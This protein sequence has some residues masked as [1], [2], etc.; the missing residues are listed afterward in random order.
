MIK[1]NSFMPLVRRIHNSQL[2]NLLIGRSGDILGEVVT[3]IMGGMAS[4]S[5]IY[6][7]IMNSDWERA[8]TLIVGYGTARSVNGYLGHLHRHRHIRER[9]ER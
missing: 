2:Y 9:I 1:N 5:T 3:T 7:G 8:L 4:G 6:H